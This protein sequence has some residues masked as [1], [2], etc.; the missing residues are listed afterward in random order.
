[1]FLRNE[2][3]LHAIRKKHIMID[4]KNTFVLQ[5]HANYDREYVKRFT[6]VKGSLPLSTRSL[7]VAT[8]DDF[9][10]M[11]RKLKEINALLKSRGKDPLVVALMGLGKVKSFLS[12]TRRRHTDGK[13][14]KSRVKGDLVT[15]EG[16]PMGTQPAKIDAVLKKLGLVGKGGSETAPVWAFSE[17]GKAAILAY[18]DRS[19]RAQGQ[20][21]SRILFGEGI[22][23]VTDRV[24]FFKKEGPQVFGTATADD[25]LI[26]AL[27][28][29]YIGTRPKAYIFKADQVY[30]DALPSGNVGSTIEEKAV[31]VTRTKA[32]TVCTVQAALHERK[33]DKGTMG[34]KKAKEP[35]GTKTNNGGD[36]KNQSPQTTTFLFYGPGANGRTSTVT[37]K[38]PQ[39]EKEGEVDRTNSTVPATILPASQQKTH[40]N[41][42]KGTATVRNSS[43]TQPVET[44][45]GINGNEMDALNATRGDVTEDERTD[46]GGK[47]QLGSE[48]A[49]QLSNL[50]STQATPT[51]A[52][53]TSVTA[54]PNR[55][56]TRQERTPESDDPRKKRRG[57]GTEE[58]QNGDEA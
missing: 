28:K 7:L 4:T 14:E 46:K 18:K 58:D 37:T 19:E 26:R 27:E 42:G 13:P 45:E 2:D 6:T 53:N 15:V 56:T 29:D 24:K 3:T 31:Q 39:T 16:I 35:T 32:P 20:N 1:M 50:Q 8:E 34:A 48:G 22:A 11:E 49:M 21:R 30:Y 36:P 55:K 38:A 52:K 33:A 9:D 10:G 5:F 44:T 54:T 57:E 12:H 51:P 17:S 23:L 25:Y 47:E 43:L 40:E 41:E